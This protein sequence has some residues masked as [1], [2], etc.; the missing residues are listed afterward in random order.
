[1]FTKKLWVKFDENLDIECWCERKKCPSESKSECKEFVVKFIEIERPK[2]IEKRIDDIKDVTKQLEVKIKREAKKFETQ[3][4]KAI[5]TF[6][7]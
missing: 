3:L 6:K 1:M 2:E 5:K 7:V 4:Q